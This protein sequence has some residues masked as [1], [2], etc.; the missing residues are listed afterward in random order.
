MYYLKP[1]FGTLTVVSK[2]ESTWENYF[3]LSPIKN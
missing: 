3:N 1:V 2:T